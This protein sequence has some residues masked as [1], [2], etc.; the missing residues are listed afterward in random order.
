MIGATLTFNDR[1]AVWLEVPAVPRA[2]EALTYDG[3][4]YTVSTVEWF[5]TGSTWTAKIACQR[6]PS[7]RGGVP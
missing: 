6:A 5:A 3:A 2:G 1:P 4:R 7:I